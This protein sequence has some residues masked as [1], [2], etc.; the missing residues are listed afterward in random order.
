MTQFHNLGIRF[1]HLQVSDVFGDVVATKRNDCEMTKYVL[2]EDE[3]RGCLRSHIHEHTSRTLLCISEHA[4][5]E[6]NRCEIH[7]CYLH[8]GTVKAVVQ[9]VIIFLSLQDIEEITLQV[10]TFYTH[11]L[12]LILVVHLIFMRY[13]I[14][15]LKVFVLH[16]AVGVHEFVDHFGGNESRFCEVSDHDITH[17]VD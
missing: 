10:R 11:R 16:G 7:L 2:A 3:H 1:L 4:V 12:Q 9:T 13:K 14:Y 6:G 17:R 8:S 15:N 5:G